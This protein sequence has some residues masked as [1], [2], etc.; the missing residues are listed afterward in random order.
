[1]LHSASGMGRK[2]CTVS[3]DDTQPAPCITGSHSTVQSPTV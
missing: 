2:W 3:H 1:M